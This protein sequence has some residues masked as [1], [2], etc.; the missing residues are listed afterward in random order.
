MATYET[1][2]SDPCQAGE[3]T[4]LNGLPYVCKEGEWQADYSEEGTITTGHDG[5]E[6]E[7][8]DGKWY[9]L[10]VQPEPEA[11]E[12]AIYLDDD[13]LVVE[14]TYTDVWATATITHPHGG[15]QVQFYNFKSM[16]EPVLINLREW[17]RV[18]K[19]GSY[20]LKYTGTPTAKVKSWARPA[21]APDRCV[22]RG[23]LQQHVVVVV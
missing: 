3:K 15:R 2:P 5:F 20:R 13:G 1:G 21:K 19:P 4:S 7:G 22:P 8:K 10:S 17:Q 23:Q 11:A 14:Y 12:V 6:Y 18:G 9:K 16:K